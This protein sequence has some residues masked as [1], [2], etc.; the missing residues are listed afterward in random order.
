MRTV[1]GRWYW[2]TWVDAASGS[3]DVAMATAAIRRMPLKFFGWK[4]TSGYGIRVRVAQF[5]CLDEMDKTDFSDSDWWALP[6]K[7]ILEMK[8]MEK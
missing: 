3:G 1:K 4:Y 8:E 6:Q 2:V 5:G 7:M